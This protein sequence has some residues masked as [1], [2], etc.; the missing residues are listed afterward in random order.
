MDFDLELK[1]QET[2]FKTFYRTNVLWDTLEIEH[3]E[4]PLEV[5]YQ[6]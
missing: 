6:D 4:T 2:E 5:G 3:E 1:D